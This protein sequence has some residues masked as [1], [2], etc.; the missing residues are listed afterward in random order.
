MKSKNLLWLA[1]MGLNFST[2]LGFAG[3]ELNAYSPN[4]TSVPMREYA[5]RQFEN[6]E[7]SR[8]VCSSFHAF[9]KAVIPVESI[10]TS[11][12]YC[13]QIA[14]VVC[15]YLEMTEPPFYLI[16]DEDYSNFYN[17]YFLRTTVSKYYKANLAAKLAEAVS[18][19]KEDSDQVS[20]ITNLAGSLRDLKDDKDIQ[21]KLKKF[22]DGSN[23]KALFAIQLKMSW[24]NNT[25]AQLSNLGLIDQRGNVLESLNFLTSNE[26]LSDKKLKTSPPFDA[27]RDLGCVLK[28]EKTLVNTYSNIITLPSD[29]EKLKNKEAV[30]RLLIYLLDVAIEKRSSV[31]DIQDKL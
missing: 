19:S 16:K 12:G 8:E 28:N 18:L 23:S 3:V 21:S 13:K 2:S 9:T 22:A 5:T 4:W 10:C 6:V 24:Y 30:K 11:D 15:S 25:G 20:S 14:N 7:T 17:A 29:P 1:L 26:M 31:N 27:I